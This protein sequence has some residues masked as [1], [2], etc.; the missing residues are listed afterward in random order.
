MRLQNKWFVLLP[1]LLA[2]CFRLDG[3]LFNPSTDI[4]GY[5]FDDFTGAV[6]IEVGERYRVETED[7]H[8]FQTPSGNGNNLW[9]TYV[10]DT[11]TIPEDTI[12]I[13]C[14]GNA[15]HM[16]FYWP[17]VKLLSHILAPQHYGVLT[18]DYQGYGLSEGEPSE[19]N[20]YADLRAMLEWLYD[21]GATPDRVVLYGFSLGSAPAS[22]VLL[23]FPE[24]EGW[25]ILEA[26]FASADVFVQDATLLSTP[27]SFVVDLEINVAEH[28]SSLQQPYLWLH[29][30]D[31]DYIPLEGHGDLVFE[32]SASTYKHAALVRGADH[33]NVPQVMQYEVYLYLIEQ[34]LRGQL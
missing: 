15:G 28:V 4:E 20:L 23:D 24:E 18:F 12:I 5:Q 19:E 13:Y 31:D 10:G 6:E 7:I 27:G 26:P 34:F 32:Q 29:G 11:S 21:R 30:Y 8:L 9:A 33:S 25:L 22:K 1:L 3:F 2:G 16:D 17:R 14:H